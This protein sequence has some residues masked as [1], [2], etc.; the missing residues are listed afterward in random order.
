MIATAN[1]RDRGVNDL[2][3]A[4]RRRFNTVVLPLPA[5]AED[6]VRIVTTRVADLT[7]AL[8]LPPVEHRAGGD[9]AGGH[10]VPRAALGGDR[11]RA[12]RGQVADGHAVGGRGD[13]GHDQRD[14]AGRAL[15]RRR[16]AAGRRRL[17]HRRRGGQG[18]GGRRA[19]LAGVPR[20]RRPG[21]PGLGRV[22]RG[23]PGRAREP[24]ARGRPGTAEPAERTRTTDGR[25]A[26]GPVEVFGIRHHG[27]G[28]ARSLVAALDAYEPDCVL[29][30]GPADADALL[31]FV[32]DEELVPPV[33]LLAYAPEEPRV[34]AFWPFAGF[35]PEWQAIRW[36]RRHGVEVA[37]CD[38]PASA[39]L[40]PRERTLLDEADASRT[41]TSP[42]P[43]G[44]DEPSAVDLLLGG[45]A[46]SGRDARGASAAGEPGPA[47]RAGAGRR[48]RRRRALVGGRR[49]GPAGRLVA[50]PA[51]ARGDGRAAPAGRAAP[52]PARRERGA[53][54]GVHA[55]DDPRRAQARPH[56]GRRGLRGLARARADRPARPGGP[57]RPAAARAAEAQG[58]LH[59]GAVDA[60]PARRRQRLRRRD[61]LARL[62][63]PPLRGAATS[64]CRAG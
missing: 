36:A 23:V 38:L 9:R 47:G 4:L 11:G 12:D 17:R 19:G 22:L 44:A 16:A 55:P 8:Q 45:P 57:G 50:F 46:A 31:R 56:P 21:T 54:G 35:S 63:R 1:D 37:F 43:T 26:R 25:P 14:R 29:V 59:L 52:R 49:R 10:R 32:G 34:A 7:A 28:S 6:E 5:D 60:P 30:E 62:V 64:R 15:R 2:S 27:P 53:A 40:A 33:A 61:H 13:L 58:R 18:P 42:A 24:R 48:L 20:R 3:S 51:G 39:T 41:R